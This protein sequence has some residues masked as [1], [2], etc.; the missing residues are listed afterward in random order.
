MNHVWDIGV[1]EDN[2]RRFAK[3]ALGADFLEDIDAIHFGQHEVEQNG[4]RAK[5]VDAIETGLPILGDFELVA[6]FF[7]AGA[8]DMGDNLVVFDDKY[9]LHTTAVGLSS[10][11]Q[12]LGFCEEKV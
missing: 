6:L 8:I 3:L 12:F 9:F 4:I 1:G 2:D 10:R 5:F 7:K 11:E